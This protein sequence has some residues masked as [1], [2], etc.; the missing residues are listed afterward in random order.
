[1][2]LVGCRQVPGF[3]ESD[4]ARR[5]QRCVTDHKEPLSVLCGQPNKVT[6]PIITSPP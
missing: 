5:A 3:R 4:I 1:L 6:F 2:F